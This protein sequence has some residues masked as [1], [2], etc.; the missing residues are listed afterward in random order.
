MP[1]RL[2]AWR[3]MP[4]EAAS[5]MMAIIFLPVMKASFCAMFTSFFATCVCAALKYRF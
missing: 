3:E 1:H 5:E 2:S 4:V